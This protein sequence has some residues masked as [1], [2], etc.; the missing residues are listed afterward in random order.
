MT[1]KKNYL[2]VG[3]SRL[4]WAEKIN[5]DLKFS[6]SLLSD[7]LPR[8]INFNNLIWASVGHYP[9]VFLNKRNEI[10]SHDINM[11]KIP[12][13]FGV[14]RALA[15]FA[16]F[17]HI[18]N[19][20]NKNIVIA[21][22]GT[23]LSITKINQKGNVIGGLLIPGFMT[24]LKSLEQNT[25]NLEIPNDLSIPEENFLLST[26]RAM[27]KGVYKSLEGAIHSSYN[28]DKDI[29][30]FCGGDAD[31]IG[32]KIKEKINNVIIEPNLAMIGMI[33]FNELT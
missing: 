28:E 20:L 26:E 21:D 3:N 15:C 22:F 13:H 11:H 8:T 9:T 33:L 25:R 12:T 4:H 31:L 7:E 10:K 30:V 5:Q 6:H 2:L 14:D 32:K 24:Q 1:P 27:V 16:A 18:E 19:V 23:T 29:L 17:N